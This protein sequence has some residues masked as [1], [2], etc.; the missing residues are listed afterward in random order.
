MAPVSDDPGEEAERFFSRMVSPA[1]WARLTEEGRASRRADGPALVADLRS[2]RGEGPPFDVTAL[3]V[4]VGVR[5]GRADVGAAPPPQRRSGWAPTSPVPVVYEIEG[6]QHGA[7]LSHP[8]HF[9]AHDPARGRAGPGPEAR[10]GMTT[11]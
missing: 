5:H 9:A 1:A 7:H 10:P 6:A 3:G 11:G 2:L 4:P 8:D